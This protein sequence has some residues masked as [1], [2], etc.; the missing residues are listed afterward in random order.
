VVVGK[1]VVGWLKTGPKGIIDQTFIGAEET[2]NN[3]RRHY[4]KNFLRDDKDAEH[5]EDLLKN[6][7]KNY[8]T[9]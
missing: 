6:K 9:F 3:I 1:Y 2:V 5:I 4:E 7:N 8:F